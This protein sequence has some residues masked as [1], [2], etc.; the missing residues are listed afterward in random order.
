MY[1]INSNNFLPGANVHFCAIGGIGM[2]A[3]AQ[4]MSKKGINIQGTDTNIAKY[5]EKNLIDS[6]ITLFNSHS[7]ANIN[8]NIHC[9]VYST[10]INLESNPEI[11]EGKKLGIP[12]I[13]RSQA[14]AAITNMQ[15][16]ILVSGSHGKT[17]TTTLVGLIL[18]YCGMSPTIISGGIMNEYNSNSHIGDSDYAVIEADES[19]GS[20]A[21]LTPYMSIITNIDREHMNHYASIDEIISIFEKLISASTQAVICTDNKYLAH[22]APSYDNIITYGVNHSPNYKIT[23]IN[24]LDSG[25]K[26]TIHHQ[27]LQYQINT[28]LLGHHNVLNITAAF[29]ITHNLSCNSDDICK[30]ITKFSGVK[31]RFTHVGVINA[32]LVIDDYAHHPTE[33]SATLDAAEQF[34]S[35]TSRNGRIIVIF[36]PHRYSRLYDLF[37]EFCA[38]LATC[39]DLILTPVYAAGEENEHNISSDTLLEKM[40]NPSA[41]VVQIEDLKNKILDKKPTQNDIIIFMGAGDISKIAYSL[42]DTTF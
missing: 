37:P 30:A 21:N 41:I 8:K 25:T 6:G 10:A 11:L 39:K 19:D 4:V 13:H 1:D 14:L 9:I 32:T 3:I 27:N 22:I 16:A 12:I 35:Q 2:S 38:C 33:I 20:L 24:T 31:R 34:M 18:D 23:N 26:F 29:A 40:N 15:K 36:Q 28:S 42:C 17:T 5:V 7:G